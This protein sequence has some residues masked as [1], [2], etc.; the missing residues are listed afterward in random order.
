MLVSSGCQSTPLLVFFVPY[1]LVSSWKPIPFE[2]FPD[3][4]VSQPRHHGTP[5]QPICGKEDLNNF[6]LHIEQHPD[7]TMEEESLRLE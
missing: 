3:C 4:H 7:G 2:A 1:P 6:R 5:E